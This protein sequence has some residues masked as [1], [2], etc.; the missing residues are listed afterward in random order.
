MG[1][2]WLAED[3]RL[4]R[5]VAIKRVR[6]DRAH[7]EADER[8]RREARAAARLA[9]PAVARLY[10]LIEGPDGDALVLEH[11]EG[12]TL[13]ELVA[14]GPLDLSRA[15]R[16]ARQVADG[17]A[18]AHARGLVHRDL[19]AENVVA[20]TDEEGREQAKILDFGLACPPDPVDPVAPDG[21]DAVAAGREV[22]GTCRSMA[23][24]QARGEA[25][26]ARADLFA[27]GVLLY[28]L[29]TGRSPFRA[30]T[31]RE[32]LER[33][34]GE[35]PEPPGHLRPG[36]PPALGTLIEALLAKDP[37]RRPR[38]A[39][40]VAHALERIE[41]LPKLAAAGSGARR[42][43]PPGSDEPTLESLSLPG[44]GGFAWRRRQRLALAALAAVLVLGAGALALWWWL[45]R[46][47]RPVRVAVLRPQVESTATDP[48]GDLASAAVN[49][50]VALVRA[51]VGLQGIAPIDPDTI[52]SVSGPPVAVA[53]ASAADEVLVSTLTAETGGLARVA[54]T[55]VRA[56]DG[57]V[58]WSDTVSVPVRGRDA[59]VAASAIATTLRGGYP[60]SQ[61]RPDV[62]EPKVRRQD[63]A[64]FVAI[65][66][67]LDS[68]RVPW[69]PELEAV[70]KLLTTSPDFVDA[71]LLAAGL[72]RTL[73]S[74]TRDPSYLDRAQAHLDRLDQLAPGDPRRLGPELEVA[75]A[76]GDQGEAAAVLAEM[77]RVEPASAEL[78]TGRS[79]L[80][81]SRGDVDS[82]IDWMKQVV[83][84]Q[85]A[86]WDLHRLADLEARHGRVA[87]A[88]RHL[89]R[90]LKLTPGNTWAEARLAALELEYGDPARAEA[91]YLELTRGK[92]Q[93]SDFT[94]L[95]LAR[96][97]Q[98]R[99]AQAAE[100]FRKALE[101]APGNQ[102]VTLD[103]AD[104]EDAL[105]H[106]EAAK[107]LY[108]EVLDGLGSRAADT[109]LT[110]VEE[111]IRAQC[112]AH[113]GED[114][115][116]IELTSSTVKKAQ[117]EAEV[118]YDAALVFA[119]TGRE[120]SALAS[121]R[122]ALAMGV[123]PRWFSLPAFGL[124][125]DREPLRS[126]L[127]RSRWH[128]AGTPG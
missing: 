118:A 114:E 7:P 103:L 38:A 56:S 21:G 4:G 63:Y 26:D 65:R 40:Q 99:Y 61:L 126:A 92:P 79:R 78:A 30:A 94:N 113:L 110:P 68:G 108:R 58:M 109:A 121:A 17:L 14:E 27:L 84:R 11:V 36:L 54:L 124:L 9:H 46:T 96:L 45:P 69:G 13:A 10:D 70:E 120:S 93:R 59:L 23:P 6:R 82:A 100:S 86:W 105:G 60:G 52:G 107:V 29:V 22:A 28:E 77:E 95:G 83:Q 53:R 127:A 106:T 72:A 33:V 2:V 89:E 104:T 51:L 35:A 5:R 64:A 42:A 49:L 81:E 125:R 3:E 115:R 116:A 97:L 123:S 66:R 31:P 24:E 12:P 75:L 90:L 119:L 1:E 44:H 55:R 88:R 87:D 91:R 15:C 112:L 117:K 34:L 71:H 122:R 19:K 73:Y 98:G 39:G 128:S 41:A 48:R 85:G 74:D 76:R 47:T 25:V 80:A 101:I 16:L 37:A 102:V 32:T 111:M 57:R 50:R 8:L 62:P 43:A 20:A 18:A 67:R